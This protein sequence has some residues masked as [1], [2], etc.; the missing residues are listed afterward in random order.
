MVP[1]RLKGYASGTKTE[2]PGV[3]I[4]G[5]KVGPAQCVLILKPCAQ[6]TSWLSQTSGRVEAQRLSR[7]CMRV[8]E[9]PTLRIS[10]AAF[11]PAQK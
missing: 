9:I 6:R 1:G 11:K 5:R 4:A 8:D 10:H 3:K 7:H 2:G